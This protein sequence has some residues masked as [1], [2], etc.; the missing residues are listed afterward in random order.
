MAIKPPQGVLTG[1]AAS[2]GIAIGPAFLVNTRTLQVPVRRIAADKVDAEVDRLKSAIADVQRELEKVRARVEHMTVKE[3][4]YILDV[5][6]LIAKDEMLV[7]DSEQYIRNDRVNAEWAVSRTTNKFKKALADVGD[8]YFKERATDIDQVG[9]RIVKVLLGRPERVDWHVSARGCVVVAHDLSPADTAQM[10]NDQV[11]GFATDLGAQTSH[12]AIL[13]RSLEIPAVVG[14]ED[15]TRQVASG[16]TVIL[17]GR[18]GVLIVDPSAEQI[19]D[20]QGRRARW[21]TREARLREESQ[22]PATT[23]DGVDLIVAANIDFVSEAE[24]V[25]AVGADGVGMFRTEY[26]FMNR[27]DLPSEEEQFAAYRDLVSSIAPHP[28]TIRTLDVG[29]DKLASP[30]DAGV[31][32]EANPALGLRAIRYGLAEPEILRAQFRAILRASAFGTVRILIPMISGLEEVRRVREILDDVQKK[33]QDAGTAFDA[34]VEFGIMIEVPAAALLAPE[35]AA[36]VDFMSIGTNDLI[37]Y[38]LAIDRVNE[39][40]A[41]L[42][43]PLHPAVLRLLRIIIDAGSRA[44]IRVNMCGEMAGETDYLLVLLG[45]GLREFSM[46]AMSIP[47][48]KRLARLIDT[49]AAVEVATT[50]L[51]LTTGQEVREYVESQMADFEASVVDQ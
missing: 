33:L 3:P 14:L 15:V 2:P 34:E 41:Y 17:D 35:L 9:E 7:G 38:T 47:R 29:G 49:Q 18:A 8:E 32:E 36:L 21:L 24:V 27:S 19:E 5:H 12:S 42:Y 16:Q 48:V 6:L 31:R 28:V 11:L 44:G 37:Q 30:V 45:L 25:A 40:V 1:I 13:A 39:H 23:I 10:R 22:E 50:A 46:N 51:S 20:Y 26:L 43:E 4:Q